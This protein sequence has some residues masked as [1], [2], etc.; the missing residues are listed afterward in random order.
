MAE[1]ETKPA[2]AKASP[3][4]ATARPAPDPGRLA[5]GADPAAVK[6]AAAVEAG[7]RRELLE[8]YD[9]LSERI[10]SDPT[11]MPITSLRA[12]V[13]GLEAAVKRMGVA[14]PGFVSAGVASDLERLGYAVDPANG[15]VYLRDADSGV[16]TRVERG[17]GVETTV[18]MPV[19][20]DL[21][22]GE[23]QSIKES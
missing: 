21:T 20:Q 2:P 14:R 19:P 12:L 9:K 8:Q 6:L 16:V 22:N 23:R 11:S 3:A 4:K 7:Q 13:A 18:D 15:D 10:G 1:N 5:D 17:T